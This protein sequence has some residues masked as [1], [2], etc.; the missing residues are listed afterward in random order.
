[1]LADT[2]P[3]VTADLPLPDWRRLGEHLPVDW[4]D[5]ALAYTGKASIR[6]RRL[7][8]EQV[9]WLVI[10][11]ALYRHH[12]VRQVLA[13]L[14]LALPDIKDTCVTDSAATQA[15]QRLGESPL[16]WLFQTSAA[17]WQQQDADRYN[18][19]GLRLLAVDGTSLKVGDS[20]DNRAHFGSPRFAN[21]AVASHPHARMV[22]LCVLDTQ[23]MLAARFGTYNQAEMGYA[24]DLLSDVPDHSVTMFDRAF[25]AAELLCNLV[26]SGTERHFVVPAK[27]NTRW[28]V[29]EGDAQDAVVEMKVSPAARKK[30]PG[31]PTHWRVRAVCVKGPQGKPVYLLTSLFDRKRFT[32]AHLQHCYSRRWQIETSYL[33]I[34]QTMMGMAVSLRSMSV[35]ATRQEIWGMLIAYNLI[36]LEMARTAEQANCKPNSISFVFALA[37][38]QFEMTHAA[39]LHAQGN[40]P[41]VLKRMRKKMINEL[42]IYRPDRE[43]DRV[44]KAKP[45]RYPERRIREPKPKPTPLT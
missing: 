6:Q 20:I 11:L 5:E 15:R 39:V 40:L 2:L 19:N 14:D 44:T 43:F 31:L 38:F 9:V 34:K 25:L 35:D 3:L 36:R 21:D 30:D 33:E 16:A 24:L 4:I 23:L 32:A 41:G 27:S 12:S 13:E 26:K 8:A 1:M 17:S 18:F 45:Q 28:T 22:T 7:P 10:A 42:N 29:I 37:T